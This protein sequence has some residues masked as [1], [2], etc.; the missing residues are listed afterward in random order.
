MKR[1]HENDSGD[2]PRSVMSKAAKERLRDENIITKL[3]QEH[4]PD[5]DSFFDSSVITNVYNDLLNSG[6]PQHKVV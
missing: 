4:W 6:F 2:A 1:R 5:K 3:A